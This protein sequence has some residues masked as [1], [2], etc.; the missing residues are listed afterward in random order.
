M[1]QKNP[2]QMP[3]R[4]F[5]LLFAFCFFTQ[6]M[7]AQTQSILAPSSLTVSQLN[8]SQLAK[9]NKL[10]ASTLHDNFQLVEV[11]NLASSQVNGKIRL[12]LS[13]LP[14]TDMIFTVTTIN[15][16][17]E[18]DYYWYGT[19]ESEVDAA[20]Q[21]GYITLMAKGGEKFGAVVFDDYSYEFQDLGNGVQAFSRFKLENGSESEC[22]QGGGSYR[23]QP[24]PPSPESAGRIIPCEPLAWE[25]RVMVL[26]TPAAANIEA[27]INNRIALALAQTN[28]A[29][30]NSQVGTGMNLVLAHSQQIA[31]T[32]TWGTND[33][34]VLANNA[35]VQNLRNQF[36]ADVVILLTNGNYGGLFGAVRAVGP[37]FNNAFGVV[38]TNSATAGRH[39]FAHEMG[40]IFG[41]RHN[42]DNTPGIGHGL[43]FN[44][45]WLIFTKTRYTLVTTT[46]ANK[47]RELHYSNPDVRIK[48][49]PTGDATFRN[50]AQQHRNTGLMVANFF[51]NA[52]TTVMGIDIIQP[53]PNVCCKSVTAE[54]DI[55]CG[56]PPYY[57]NWTISYDGVNWD[58]LP[59]SEI[60]TFNTA[61][62]RQTLIIELAVT[63]ANGQFRTVRR[64]YNADCGQEVR[65]NKPGNK[66]DKPAKEEPKRA[67]IIQN[68]Y[69][70]P[71]GSVAKVDMFVTEA[72]NVKIEVVDVTGNTLRQV[73]N[74]TLPKGR[75][76]IAINTN[77]LRPGTYRLRVVS[78]QKTEYYQFVVL[79]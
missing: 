46:P 78:K 39:T 30:I 12:A 57:F 29:Y 69:P 44:T 76:T 2:F 38:Q 45:G 75:K 32:E 74:G 22:S 66:E 1:T 23:T 65:I 68:L 52:P 8:S 21:G 63:D 40:H 33:V 14:C 28:Q 71:S 77:G 27:N 61:C 17:S 4:A 13:S 79:R 48:N 20:C 60:V 11:Q 34:Q 36:Q 25:V 3:A 37:N 43:A 50:N 18:N 49:T 31:F 73:Y 64:Y 24:P 47:S 9:F 72:G 58:L 70:N 7:F 6:A 10:S 62:N 26:W 55:Y 56:T 54:A 59:N 16:T 53:D 67:G 42:D 15:Y 51:Q 5:V 19:I 41:C 35:V